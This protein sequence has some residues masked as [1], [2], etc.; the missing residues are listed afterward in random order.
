MLERETGEKYPGSRERVAE[1]GGL[2]QLINKVVGWPRGARR[3]EVDGAGLEP[4]A[5]ERRRG[6]RLE[7][8]SVNPSLSSRQ[9]K[10]RD[11]QLD[12][13]RATGTVKLH[14]DLVWLSFAARKVEDWRIG[15]WVLHSIT[16]GPANALVKVDL[17]FH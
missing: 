12:D 11:R 4:L 17:L 10:R 15:W 7:Q 3:A 5:R 13:H 8:K 1:E 16:S 2:R 14:S 9:R 6:G